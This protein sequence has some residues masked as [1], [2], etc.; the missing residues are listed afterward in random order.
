MAEADF[1]EA[2]KLLEPLT[3]AS[4]PSSTS[5]PQNPPPALE[6]SR[7]CN[8]L[9]NL[10]RTK[11]K[12][13]QAAN[14]FERAIGIHRELVKKDPSK[15]EYKQELAQ[16]YLNL[17]LLELDENRFELAERQNHEALDLIEEL[18]SPGPSLSMKRAEAHMIRG[19]ILES[20]SKQLPQ[21]QSET[22]ESQRIL[23]TLRRIHAR[24]HPEFHNMYTNFALNYANLTAKYLQSGELVNAQHSLESL[25]RVMPELSQEDRT[26]FAGQFHQLQ[27][28]LRDQK[29]KQ[30]R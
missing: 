21:A 18:A 3:A 10:L 30:I 2:V 1:R 25:A 20:Q 6:L 15:R 12:P 4:A 24:E 28:Q 8:N 27:K 16:F 22:E 29:A 13:E 11:G 5:E 19:W 9:G 26:K 23:E 14:F 7:V 17:G